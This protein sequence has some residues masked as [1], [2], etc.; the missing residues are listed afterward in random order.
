MADQSGTN[1]SHNNAQPI[2]PNIPDFEESSRINTN[3]FHVGSFGALWKEKLLPRDFSLDDT[4]MEEEEDEENVVQELGCSSATAAEL[5]VVCSVD[6]LKCTEVDCPDPE[7]IPDKTDL[8]T[9]GIRRKILDRREDTIIVDR[10]CRQE[11]FAYELQSYAVGKK[12]KDPED[13]IDE[14]ELILTLNIFYPVIFQ[15]H[16]EYKPYQTWLVLG[17]QKLTELRDAISCVSDLQISGEYSN[18]PD[19]EP[20]N[21]SKD[22]YKSSFLYFENV[23]YNDM[24]FPECRD[25]SRTVIEWA[26][27]RDRGYSDFRCEK[28]EDFTFNDLNIKIGFPYVYC[29]QGD[30]EHI[31]IITD[32]RLAHRDDCL[33]KTLYP[34]PIKKHWLWTRRCAVCNLYTARWVTNNDHLA[35]EDPCFFCDVCFRLLHYDTEGNKLGEFLAF[36][37]V[38][39]GIF[40]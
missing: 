29:H 21:L 27:E 4:E 19:M 26:Q 6:A 23:F 13:Y 22:L 25:L 40:N 12:P 33:D 18:N 39:P 10:I 11:M 36:P 31:I 3:V 7:V 35:P 20:E 28:M 38:D 32:I 17:S 37:Y 2:N 1:N 9:V 24:R 14:G 16:R 30:C 15:K 5:E 34:L 8:V